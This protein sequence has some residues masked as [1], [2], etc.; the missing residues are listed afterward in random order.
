MLDSKFPTE[1]NTIRIPKEIG[2]IKDRFKGKSDNTV[3][4][5]QDAHDI[6]EAQKNIERLIEHFQSVYGVRLIAAEGAAS[7]LDPQIFRSFPDKKL[8]KKIVDDYYDRAEVTGTVGAAILSEQNSSYYGVEDWTLY[9]D[10]LR[11]Y[12]K[13]LNNETKLT[14][15]LKTKKASLEQAK[16]LIYSKE[17]LEVDQAVQ[18]FEHNNGRLID[19]L[20]TL[21]KY[22]SPKS[23]E[24]TLLLEEAKNEK[25]DHSK[26]EQEVKKLVEQVRSSFRAV[27]QLRDDATILSTEIASATSGILPRNDIE[28]FNQTYQDF[29][30]S[31]VS[32]EAFALRIQ[33]IAQK[34]G[35][36]IE[37]SSALE[38]SIQR[39]KSLRDLEGSQFF[40]ELKF[41]INSV[42][43][44]L[45]KNDQQRKLEQR[46]HE[47]NLLDKF[48][49][50]ELSNEE[51]NEIQAISNSEFKNSELEYHFAFYEAATKRDKAFFDN[52]TK[53]MASE[54]SAMFIS[55]GFHTEGL[56]QQLK[57]NKISYV[58][59]TPKMNRVPQQTLYREHMR[60]NV[61]W[62]QYFKVEKGTVNL[63]EAFVRATRDKFINNSKDP[64]LLKTWRD[65]IVRDFVEQEKTTEVGNY[66][67]FIDELMQ[68]KKYEELK[69]QWFSNLDQFIDK[70]KRLQAAHQLNEQNLLKLLTPS[71]MVPVAEAPAVLCS[72]NVSA[73]V[74][75]LATLRSELR[76]PRGKQEVSTKIGKKQIRE[77]VRA[78]IAGADLSVA[79]RNLRPFK[80]RVGINNRILFGR[81]MLISTKDI[82][83]NTIVHVVPT[84]L[85]SKNPSK[86]AKLKIV[87]KLKGKEEQF[88]D[89]E[90]K[91]TPNHFVKQI[92]F[93]EGVRELHDYISALVDH[94]D[95]TQVTKALKP[96][97]T[98]AN[99]KGY[100][101]LNRFRASSVQTYNHN[102]PENTPII[103][104]PVL[105]DENDL[106][107]GAYLKLKATINQEEK[108]WD[109][110]I[111][112]EEPY[113]ALRKPIVVKI[114]KPTRKRSYKKVI[115]SK[116]VR[117]KLDGFSYPADEPWREKIFDYLTAL[118][119]GED[120]SQT[121]LALAAHQGVTNKN[122]VYL[123]KILGKSHV[124]VS[125]SISL[126]AGLVYS[127]TPILYD[128]SNPSLGAYLKFELDQIYM[129]K[130]R[131]PRKVWYFKMEKNSPYIQKM[132]APEAQGVI[133]YVQAVLKKGDLSKSATKLRPFKCWTSSL[134]AVQFG[135]IDRKPVKMLSHSLPRNSEVTITPIFFDSSNPSKGVYFVAT[136]GTTNVHFEAGNYRHF[137]RISHNSAV[138]PFRAKSLEGIPEFLAHIRAVRDGKNLTET[139]SALKTFEL[140]VKER[141][142][143]YFGLVDGVSVQFYNDA[144]KNDDVVT[145]TPIDIDENDKN[146]GAFFKVSLGEKNIAHYKFKP[147]PRHI[148]ERFAPGNEE[149][150]NYIVAFNKGKGTKEAA[151]HLIPF[152]MKTVRGGIYFG[153]IG[154]EE[155]M[156]QFRSVKSTAGVKRMIEPNTTAHVVPKLIDSQDPLKGIRIEVQ[157]SPIETLEFFITKEGYKKIIKDDLKA[158]KKFKD[159]IDK[160]PKV[161]IKYESDKVIRRKYGIR[162]IHDYIHA[163]L[164]HDD[165]TNVTEALVPFEGKTGPGGLRLGRVDNNYLPPVFQNLPNQ[166]PVAI[167]PKMI[168]PNDPA[169]GAFLQFDAHISDDKLLTVYYR[170]ISDPPY[171]RKR[172]APGFME[173]VD[174]VNALVLGQDLTEVTR[175][176][177]P[178]EKEAVKSGL[179]FGMIGKNRKEFKQI[180]A[181][182][183]A[184]RVGEKA[185]IAPIW[186]D[187]KDPSK[188]AFL[189]IKGV[190]R[191]GKT[192]AW[193]YQF[194]KTPTFLEY[195][196]AP[197]NKEIMDYVTALV[198]GDDLTEVTRALKPY[199]TISAKLNV[200]FGSMRSKKDGSRDTPVGIQIH[201]L[202]ENVWV[203]ITPI[204]NDPNDVSKGAFVKLVTETGKTYYYKFKKEA[205][206]TEQRRPP[207]LEE[208][209]N[210]VEALIKG[211]DIAEIVKTLK[212]FK[213]IQRKDGVVY[214]GD[215]KRRGI[216]KDFPVSFSAKTF[217][218]GSELTVTPTLNDPN[219]LSKGVF[220]KVEVE[221]HESQEFGIQKETPYIF[222]LSRYT[223]R[224]EIDAIRKVYEQEGDYEVT[225]ELTNMMTTG[226]LSSGSIPSEFPLPLK[227]KKWGFETNPNLHV[228]TNLARV[229]A[230]FKRVGEELTLVF[231]GFK[232]KHNVEF[233]SAES[234]WRWN[235][236]REHF[237]LLDTDQVQLKIDEI[238]A[239]Y[240]RTEDF[241]E[242]I[243]I[244]PM[245]T[246]DQL[247]SG[248]LPS[249]FPLPTGENWGSQEDRDMR[250]GRR[251]LK[252]DLDIERNK[253]GIKIEFIG[254]TR[255]E[256]RE[257][258]TI[259]RLL[260]N[261]EKI[262]LNGLNVSQ[263]AR[264]IGVSQQGLADHLERYPEN[265]KKYGIAKDEG[266]IAAKLEKEGKGK[267]EGLNIRQAARALKINCWSLYDH[268]ERHPKDLKKYGVVPRDSEIPG[269]LRHFGKK[270]LK[271]LNISQ[272]AQLMQ[273]SESGLAQHL[274]RHPKDLTKYGIEPFESLI[275]DK[276]KKFGKENL[277]GLSIRA[278]AKL[279]GV[280]HPGLSHHLIMHPEDYTVYGIRRRAK[281]GKRLAKHGWEQLHGKNIGQVAVIIKVSFS[282]LKEYLENHLEDITAYG[283]IGISGE[284]ESAKSERRVLENA[285]LAI[286]ARNVD[287]KTKQDITKL[288]T[289]WQL[290]NGIIPSTF[291]LPNGETWKTKGN[292]NLFIGRNLQQVELEIEKQ[293]DNITVQFIGHPRSELR[294]KQPAKQVGRSTW[295]WDAEKGQ[296]VLQSS[297]V[298]KRGPMTDYDKAVN[299]FGKYRVLDLA[300]SLSSNPDLM[301]QALTILLN[302]QGV[303]MTEQELAK[304][305]RA[306]IL[307][308]REGHK[309]PE[310]TTLQPGDPFDYLRGLMKLE[311]HLQKLDAYDQL[312]LIRAFTRLAF[313]D[314]VR[315][316]EKSRKTMKDIL[317]QVNKEGFFGSLI[318]HVENELASGLKNQ[319]A[320]IK[321]NLLPHQ[322][323]GSY[324]MRDSEKMQKEGIFGFL[325]EDDTRMGKTIQTFAA[326]D[327]LWKSAVIVPAG[328]MDTWEEQ[329]NEHTFEVIFRLTVPNQNKKY[330]YVEDGAVKK[331][332]V[333]V[334][335][336]ALLNK[337]SGGWQFIMVRGS[338]EKKRQI[339]EENRY[340]KGII[341]LFSVEDFQHKSDEEIDAISEG[342]DMMAVDE[343]QKIETYSGVGM[344]SSSLQAEAIHKIRTKRKW[345]LSAS[346]YTSHPRQLFSVFHMLHKNPDTGEV[347]DPMYANRRTF[348]R[349]LTGNLRQ[350]RWLYALKARLGFRRTKNEM[351]IV[352]S[353][354]KEIAPEQEGVYTVSNEQ[355]ELILKVIK[356]L[357]EYLKLYN[358]RVPEEERMDET[359]IGI[360]L[361]LQFLNWAMTEPNMLGENI[362]SN[363]FWEKMDQIVNK[364]ISQNKK[365][366]IFAQNIEMIN[367]II[368][369]FQ[370]RGI[371][372]ARIDGTVDGYA[373]DEQGQVIRGFYDADGKLKID[374]KGRQIT[375]KA[376]QRYIFQNDPDVK[377]V[378]MNIRAG[379][380]IDLGHADWELYAQL[381]E[382]YVQYYQSSDRAIGINPL[383]A[384]GKQK[385][386]EVLYM[387]AQYPKPF[388]DQLASFSHLGLDE[389]T[390]YALQNAGISS[391]EDLIKTKLEQL[392]QIPGIDYREAESLIDLAKTSDYSRVRHGT[393]AE[394]L[395]NGIMGED[396]QRFELVMEG[397]PVPDGVSERRAITRLVHA[398]HGFLEDPS[399]MAKT[400]KEKKK[401]ESAHVLYAIFQ[402]VRGDEDAEEKVLNLVDQYAKTEV[403][404]VQLTRAMIENKRFSAQDLKWIGPVFQLSNKLY[405]DQTL[406]LLPQIFEKMWL[407][408]LT[409]S[410]L[411]ERGPPILA[412]VAELSPELVFPFLA[413][414]HAWDMG[415]DEEDNLQPTHLGT[416]T[417]FQMLELIQSAGFS[418]YEQRQ[419]MR[420]F[421]SA[422]FQM[423]DLDSDQFLDFVEFVRSDLINGT[424]TLEEKIQIFEELSALKEAN[425]EKYLQIISMR[426]DLPEIL[427]A[428]NTAMNETFLKLF[429]LPETDTARRQ[430]LML[431]HKWVS[432]R[433]PVLMMAKLQA[434]G[435]TY[436]EHVKRFKQFMGHVLDGTNSAWR[437]RQEVDPTGYEIKYRQ[438]D[439]GFWETFTREEK[440]NL[441]TVVASQK[442]FRRLRQRKINGILSFLEE[443]N[444]EQLFKAFGDLGETIHQDLMKPGS[445]GELTEALRQKG[446]QRST[447]VESSGADSKRLEAIDREIKA[448]RVRLNMVEFYEA[449]K[450]G[451][452]EE[453]APLLK[454]VRKTILHN[455]DIKEGELPLEQMMKDLEENLDQAGKPR[456]Y[457]DVEI[458]ITS[459]PDLIMRRGMLEEDLKNCFN[460]DYKPA[461][462]A[463]LIDDLISRNKML[464][465][466][467][468]KGRIASVSMLKIRQDEKGAPVIMVERPLYRWGYSFEHEIAQ[469][470]VI[471][472]LPEMKDTA[473]AGDVYKGEEKIEELELYTT[474]SRG[475]TEYHETLFGWR[476]RASQVHHVAGFIYKSISSVTAEDEE[477]LGIKRINLDI[478]NTPHT[479]LGVGHSNR[480]MGEF[481]ALAKRSGISTIVDIR[482]KPQSQYYPHF[483]QAS[484]KETLSEN[485]I[486][487][488]WLGDTLGGKLPEFNGNFQAYMKANPQGHFTEGIQRLL[489]IIE[490]SKEG[491]AILCSEGATEMCHRRFILNYLS[492][493]SA[494]PLFEQ[495][496]ELRTSSKTEI[497]SESESRQAII[498][499]A[500]ALYINE[501]I[502]EARQHLLSYSEH[503]FGIETSKAGLITFEMIGSENVQISAL[504]VSTVVW[505]YPKED[506]HGEVYL[507]FRLSA[508]ESKYYQFVKQVIN[509]NYYSSA[510]TTIIPVVN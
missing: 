449:L 10:G 415:Q 396:K 263:A 341:L 265:S 110:D 428:I 432:L 474:G 187:P 324:A 48:I 215:L 163:V 108:T 137:F 501:G 13:A 401:I 380:G 136:A 169:K 397:I 200:H 15:D 276:L 61:S 237:D 335:D 423:I 258:Y 376:Y 58:L 90:F 239:Q 378:V 323:V 80:I 357:G 233:I 268:F 322:R 253:G 282:G 406:R 197:G 439:P 47:L 254:H 39:Q 494:G 358:Q 125:L 42:K 508:S 35:W 101:Y 2:E 311:E 272:A 192:R 386:V 230:V 62:K 153:K 23:S 27:A 129:R 226:K 4:L 448:L 390:N 411:I 157:F 426:Q 107:K 73:D 188:G 504:P 395:F 156:L 436:A 387:M 50:L 295:V 104:E 112:H 283:I 241:K 334:D 262:K 85:D 40:G 92:E 366:I 210:Y 1:L 462:I 343:G 300:V 248:K 159:P 257:E 140:K 497:V 246:P 486:N 502:E 51:W 394:L 422:L 165:L 71:T 393:P 325:L 225:K 457:E 275:P 204:L 500:K 103:F 182:V 399:M 151:A 97:K 509:D 312:V 472:K 100:I 332:V 374:S 264:K 161:R 425:P 144:L 461:Q 68:D 16:K 116:L 330:E 319:P 350:M 321:T 234:H 473:I 498:R 240:A 447:L 49:H 465:V 145:I 175:A 41:Y 213:V 352:Y 84:L 392:A 495:R 361:K 214:I 488:I 348:N 33:E 470:L 193:Y 147:E 17:L 342:L 450:Q 261:F 141:G 194:R 149:L 44:L 69:R 455:P 317:K 362:S 134:G 294:V 496:S 180:T 433:A 487:Y 454:A 221:G 351:G 5:I 441:Y 305:S 154:N 430:I 360:L 167:T 327:P 118:I 389:K 72:R 96:I 492:S 418:L 446:P 244:T 421:V 451:N 429:G 333:Y 111:T 279:I 128:P 382:N 414:S 14:Q 266:F 493:A 408:E 379:L 127:L 363:S 459:D 186:N 74:L 437:N 356:N 79:A 466:V 338:A 416:Q 219:D 407:K 120:L 93:A 56:I 316:I 18:A 211:Q 438:D 152:D 32:A 208:V 420:R 467:R 171:L 12:L 445:R 405:R 383:V 456:K 369:R 353:K 290:K 121:S 115:G 52:L 368:A 57:Q 63:Y 274:Q 220:L 172:R 114:L 302:E 106:S 146:K 123:G 315:D 31:H 314:F 66:T 309:A 267:L 109:Y 255:S 155:V 510:V 181:S 223:P 298:A 77:Y 301:E 199:R 373:L 413:A 273:I 235:P 179:N 20:I 164:N 203:D 297:D 222:R 326:L 131:T 270:R 160:K 229:E 281:I 345:I 212:P 60:G 284:F 236:K 67:K 198:A 388:L 238:K 260:R 287:F 94:K 464:A 463:T 184:L 404:P 291:P 355:S 26:I 87:F 126:P 143:V 460:L 336:E 249:T 232:R 8:L 55:G 247:R 344:S 469:A 400:K 91:D 359:S 139:T 176:L 190:D 224:E 133:D 434:G 227:E 385:E 303:E 64:N 119:Q 313:H 150:L 293:G 440:V 9:E 340:K 480:S 28:D 339:V 206:Y 491:V 81:N 76:I 113:L 285:I 476:P 277:Q 177:V 337:T 354:K 289:A 484:F 166:T 22:Q 105:I 318:Q 148:E 202:P 477:K 458:Q 205:A 308:L 269:L 185:R 132:T 36:N 452:T 286:Y 142:R 347:T 65:E 377:I 158:E 70:A 43:E 89:Y 505:I 34:Y 468:V 245:F 364:R 435:P 117:A 490:H 102:I 381:P 483:N 191:H 419:W 88:I 375:A 178:F 299:V 83:L 412:Q 489:N 130:G 29:Q 296:F 168:D 124:K 243:D 403:S 442:D 310:G 479:L 250:I 424:L 499:Y 59:V 482:S 306:L 46:D 162:Q 170:F 6:P 280:S 259:P 391:I 196:E 82:P 216:E 256:I 507:E 30:T 503:G 25:A 7:K 252:V 218:V 231:R 346:P 38:H 365:G 331:L 349:L 37:I 278:A 228:G 372:V 217:P 320:H 19:L 54:R 444:F 189:K 402:K 78:L 201:G 271:T 122:G 431:G 195:R 307:N 481:I 478:K 86:G 328:V 410:D 370:G 485:G 138:T 11:N 95:L 417:L 251:L 3:V 21:S 409:V 173:V 292:R 24:I 98:E 75:G 371:R 242:V 207:G 471:S 135:V 209:L 453:I 506:P 427:K 443:K 53:L 288:F 304:L 398:I 329:F 174:Y 367:R 99:K 183:T 475:P 384:V 45:L